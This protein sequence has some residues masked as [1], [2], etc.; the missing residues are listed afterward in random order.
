MK[1]IQ[2]VS[3]EE[4]GVCCL[5]MLANY[6]ISSKIDKFE[7]LENSNLQSDGMSIMDLEFTADKYNILLDSYHCNW[8]EIFTSKPR[9]P[10]IIVMKYENYLHYVIGVYKDKKVK[11]YDP[12]GETFE[13]DKWNVPTN[14]YN[15]CIFSQYYDKKIDF[16]LTKKSSIIKTW[17]FN[18]LISMISL[19]I[20]LFCINLLVSH[21]CSFIMSIKE[22]DFLFVLKLLIFFSLTLITKYLSD[23][24]FEKIE[25]WYFKKVYFRVLNKFK[26][27][28]IYK[29]MNFFKTI[30]QTNLLFFYEIIKQYITFVNEFWINIIKN[31]IFMSVLFILLIQFKWIFLI[32]IFSNALNFISNFFIGSQNNKFQKYSVEKMNKINNL[33]FKYCESNKIN[34]NVE[35]RYDAINLII[36]KL[37]SY[38]SKSIKFNFRNF[39]I[40]TWFSNFNQ[41]LNVITFLVIFVMNNQT[42]SSS[43]VL[44][45]SLMG[46]WNSA[47]N[48]LTHILI[49]RKNFKI[50][51]DIFNRFIFLNNLLMNSKDI[52][53]NKID[54]LKINNTN[55]S[56]GTILKIENFNIQDFINDKSLYVNQINISEIDL[57]TFWNKTI[58][59]NTNN[60]IDIQNI[61]QKN[62]KELDDDMRKDFLNFSELINYN[63]S[64]SLSLMHLFI[65]SLFDLSINKNKLIMIDFNFEFNENSF[66]KKLALKIIKKIMENNFVLFINTFEFKEL[67]SQIYEN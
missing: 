44:C 28:F 38:E 18:Y 16:R 66:L 37:I 17:S 40:S 59:R 3:N 21:I 67:S 47:F 10:F 58:I 1:I 13:Y 14:Y 39:K 26:K 31:I 22:F 62:I 24:L 60:T 43:M 45:W 54:N 36:K 56:N 8:N 6:Y 33:I 2:Q 15:I 27:I 34:Q 42:F 48:E 19:S 7:I 50:I 52:K 29:N 51:K 49:S 64:N 20:F 12:V 32:I 5:T 46:L 11:I 35:N 30:E 57:E 25:N 41:L 63:T 61:F 9:T 4:C 53:L 55:L 65:F 23:L